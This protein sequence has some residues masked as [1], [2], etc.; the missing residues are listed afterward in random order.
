MKEQVK[1]RMEILLDQETE[2]RRLSSTAA[3]TSGSSSR[4]GENSK[5]PRGAHQ[6]ESL[7]STAPGSRSTLG[8]KADVVF[9][10]DTGK[11]VAVGA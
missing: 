3:S 6:R 11:L 9:H 4:Q 10:C 2:A 8:M 5:A 1:T 7:S